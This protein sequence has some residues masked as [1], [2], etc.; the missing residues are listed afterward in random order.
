MADATGFTNI[1]DQVVVTELIKRE[2]KAIR[3]QA[4]GD[5]VFQEYGERIL[6]LQT[7]N[8]RHIKVRVQ[9]VLPTG[10]AQFKAP[11]AVPALWTHRP[12]LREQVIELVDIDEMHRIDPID[13]LKFKSP[14]PNVVKEATWDLTARGAAMQDRNELR[15]EWMRWE[16]L[17]G[18]LVV[19][20]PAAGSV[21]I[22]YGIPAANFPTAGTP[23][24]D[25]DDSDIVEDLW[26]LGT[27]SL[28][29]AGI[30]LSKFHFTS[31]VYR[32]MR[33]NVGIRDSLSSYGRNVFLPTDNDLR[34]LLREG[35][36]FVVVDSGYLPENQQNYKLTKWIKDGEVFATTPDYKYAGRRIGEVADGW[37]LVGPAGGAGQQP[38]ARQGMQSEWIYNRIGQQTLLRQASARMPKIYAPE[39]LAWF[40]AYTPS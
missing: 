28:D 33:R 16:A 10:L 38:V 4:G 8:G 11:G 24:T 26:T 31:E 18:T 9:D 20:Y 22:N 13:M 21:T 36:Q 15:T 17:R 6:P 7:V 2:H 25:I 19:S 27:V 14:D 29:R 23:W 1:F 40:T 5:E 3:R 34:D 32:Y 30:Y 37:V 39:A 12:N 35:S